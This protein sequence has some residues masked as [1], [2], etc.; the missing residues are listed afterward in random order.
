MNLFTFFTKPGKL[1]LLAAMLFSVTMLQAQTYQYD[2]AWGNT[3]MTLKSQSATGVNLNFSITE[4][5]LT[6]NVIDGVP[7]QN[8]RMANAFL[9][10]DEGAPDLPGFGR[11]IAI[12][13]GATAKLNVLSLRTETIQGVEIAPAPRIPLDTEKGPLEYNKN[14]GLYTRDAFY[15]AEPFKLSEQ[16]QL[17]GVDA[18]IIGIT[19][20]QY[21]PVTKELIIYRDVEIEVVFEG[22][23][24]YFGQDRLRSRWFDPILQDALL[25]AESLPK[26]DYSARFHNQSQRDETGYEYLIVIPDDPTWLPYAEQIKEWR[27]LQG[28]YTGIMTL[29]E[30]GTN[31]VS[32]LENFFNDAYNNWD[33]PPVAV[34]LMADYGSNANTQITSPIWDGYCVSDQ[35]FADVNN[36]DMADMIFARMT[37]QN[38]T[39]LQTMVSKMLD[40]EANP[41]TDADFYNKPI[42]ALGWQTERWFQICSET[43]GGYWREVKG[44]EPVRINAIYSGSPGSSWSS[45]QNTW[46]VVD[47][48]GPNGLG[49]IPATPAELGG[50][51]GGTAQMVI[52]AIN[53][54]SFALQHRDHGFEQGWGEPSYSSSDIDGLTNTDLSWI[55]SIN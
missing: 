53:D 32:G 3:G 29:D 18:A 38:E 37:A 42:T 55:F 30:I 48:F 24:G 13:Q 45:N 47:Y 27:M 49:Y 11:Y 20:Y 54:G 2:D 31:S 8:I 26:V 12:P 17:R 16:T 4:F 34:L 9:P 7:M 46:M 22:G 14:D 10:N 28:I 19:P 51:S 43:V 41:P 44:K 33:I 25:N 1:V 5:T 15:P 35:I 39:H 23:N 6:E 50:W 36:N 52:N 40:Y 21:N